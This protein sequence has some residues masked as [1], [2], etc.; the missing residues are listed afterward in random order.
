MI[1]T[2]IDL[3]GDRSAFVYRDVS[4]LE[5]RSF[6]KRMP[7]AFFESKGSLHGHVAIEKV[8]LV[9]ETQLL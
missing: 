5:Q 6:A 1:L 8:Q 7:A 9:V 4:V 2:D 3:L